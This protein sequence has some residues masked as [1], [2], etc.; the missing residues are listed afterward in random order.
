MI[1]HPAYNATFCDDRPLH[2]VAYTDA[3][4]IGGAEISL[5]HLI[6]TVSSHI[7]IT[8]IG[9]SAKV[10]EAIGKY[11]PESISIV[12]PNQ[13]V[14]SY[15]SHIKTFQ[16]IRPDILHFNCCTPWANAIGLTTALFTS[17]AKIVRVDQ[18][19]LRTTDMVTL[20]RHR[21]LC[22]RVDAHVAVGQ[23]SAQGWKTFTP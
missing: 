11:R 13:G 19:P 5:G 3:A 9:T 18:L 1:N 17:R 22:L 6:A 4:G 15:L 8:V 14:S 7:R 20:W 10:V 21:A 12:L 16:Q 23:A 2:V